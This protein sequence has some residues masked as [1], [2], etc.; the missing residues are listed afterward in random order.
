MH[1]EGCCRV[2]LFQIP[3][4][5][6]VV[7]ALDARRSD[8]TPLELWIA[9]GSLPHIREYHL[10]HI[11]VLPFS[12]GL[13]K[14]FHELLLAPHPSIA[15]DDRRRRTHLAHPLHRVGAADV[16]PLLAVALA[17]TPDFASLNVGKFDSS[18]LQDILLN[19]GEEHRTSPG[20][21][22][23]SGEQGIPLLIRESLGTG[24]LVAAVDEHAAQQ[25]RLGL[26]LGLA[27]QRLDKIH[28]LL[29][30]DALGRDGV[31]D[32]EEHVCVGT[33][34]SLELGAD[35][36]QL[37]ELGVGE[38]AELGHSRCAGCMGTLVHQSLRCSKALG[39][40]LK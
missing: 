31:A 26:G 24:H 23:P 13:E 34:D 7:S 12:E 19:R 18:R 32:V 28:H 16:K 37:V 29:H 1:P 20:S 5:L 27:R 4:N 21:R 17:T 22:T 2:N 36:K 30:R 6:K 33:A 3:L 10:E 25:L 38:F 8:S 39:M 9:R 35:V 11:P 15:L 14:P 40:I